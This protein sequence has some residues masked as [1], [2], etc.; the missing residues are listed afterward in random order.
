VAIPDRPRAP[1]PAT[2]NVACITASTM[3]DVGFWQGIVEVAH[4]RGHLRLFLQPAVSI[5]LGTRVGLSDAR[6][7]ELPFLKRLLLVG[8]SRR[9]LAKQAAKATLIPFVVAIVLDGLLQYITL[10]RV[11]PL[12]ALVMGV[13]LIWLPFSVARSLANRIA[14]RSYRHHEP[15]AAGGASP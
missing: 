12:A 6:A 14:R 1:A 7:G 2:W 3:A 11:R 15:H 5:A 8:G 10:D 13:A 4:G 9:E